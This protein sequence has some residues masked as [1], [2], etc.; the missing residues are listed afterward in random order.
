MTFAFAL[1]A[2]ALI[3]AISDSIKSAKRGR[4]NGKLLPLDGAG[5]FRRDVVDHA[6]DAAHFIHNAA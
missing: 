1:T 4:L 2:E 5:R 3:K 6:V